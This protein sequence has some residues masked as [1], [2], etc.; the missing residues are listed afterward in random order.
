MKL[1]CLSAGSTNFG[2]LARY[3]SEGSHL[4]GAG[5]CVESKRTGTACSR[6]MMI[7]ICSLIHAK[8]GRG[9][10]MQQG[11]EET[12]QVDFGFCVSEET[13]GS[14]RWIRTVSTFK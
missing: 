5:A 3:G 6:P 12:R 4:V 13:N 2:Y 9:S 1:Y 7:E 11:S 14:T 10:E 8:T